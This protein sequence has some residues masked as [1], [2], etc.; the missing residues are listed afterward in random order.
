M[1]NIWCSTLS[2]ASRGTLNIKEYNLLHKKLLL[3]DIVCMDQSFS[4]IEKNRFDMK[5]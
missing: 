2:A 5:A 1:E 3:F 4:Q